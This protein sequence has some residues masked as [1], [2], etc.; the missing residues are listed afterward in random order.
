MIPNAT[1]ASP[2]F[3]QAIFNAIHDEKYRP[4]IQGL[5]KC[6]DYAFPDSKAPSKRCLCGFRKQRYKLQVV[7]ARHVIEYTLYQHGERLFEFRS[8]LNFLQEIQSSENEKTCFLQSLRRPIRSTNFS[9]SVTAKSLSTYPISHGWKDRLVQTMSKDSANQSEQIVRMLSEVCR[10][11]ELR[12]EESE[13]PFREERKRSDELRSKL[14]SAEKRIAECDAQSAVGTDRILELGKGKQAMEE[15]SMHY[16]LRAQE[17]S[18]CLD[19]IKEELERVKLK[20]HVDAE[21]LSEN[22]RQQDLVYMATL[23]VKDEKFEAQ[24]VDYIDAKNKMQNFEA[25]LAE[26]KSQVEQLTAKSA[27]DNAL[28]QGLES[29]LTKL[30]GEMGTREANIEQFIEREKS[31]IKDKNE[32]GSKLVELNEHHASKVNEMRSLLAM[33]KTSAEKLIE[34]HRLASEGWEVAQYQ[35]EKSNRE[36]VALLRK[37]LETTKRDASMR[38]QGYEKIV[39]DLRNEITALQQDKDQRMHEIAQAQELGSKLMAVVG[40]KRPVPNTLFLKATELGAGTGNMELVTRNSSVLE[41]VKPNHQGIQ[42]NY[43][44]RAKVQSGLTSPFISPPV[45][46]SQGRSKHPKFKSREM[47]PLA[48]I[49]QASDSGGFR[50]QHRMQPKT[51][52]HGTERLETN[53]D[54]NQMPHEIE[55]DE[56]S[57]D[58]GDVFSSTDHR[59]LFQGHD[60]PPACSFDDSTREF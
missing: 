18:G 43:A 5:S 12:C 31:L 2:E 53:Q 34:S 39:L 36:T 50:S 33:E 29:A 11:L 15:E 46:L 10:D 3:L 47:S 4:Y 38:N 56:D 58:E 28:I 57:F 6:N 19:D 7:L 44:K 54:E 25:Q 37:D 48:Q 60:Q 30:K 21:S 52:K 26:S 17:I 27:L 14:A 20:A 35:V 9:T 8:I 59:K 40:S 45:R 22:M 32:L 23:A 55:V 49:D 16:K 24:E 1:N 41:E 51:R 42:E 13:K